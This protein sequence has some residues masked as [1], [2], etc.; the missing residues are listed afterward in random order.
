MAT[1][2]CGGRKVV[3]VAHRT[4]LSQRASHE[5]CTGAGVAPEAACTVVAALGPACREGGRA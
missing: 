3:I 4:C 2:C 5:D 1:G